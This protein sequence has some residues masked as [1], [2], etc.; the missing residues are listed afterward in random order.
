MGE[1]EV[2]VP[3]GLLMAT[4][5]AETAVTVR[6]TLVV[7]PGPVVVTVTLVGPVGTVIEQLNAPLALAV[8]EH[9]VTLPG[10]VMATTE[11]GVAVPAMGWV[12]GPGTGG[13]TVKVGAP[14]AVKLVVVLAVPPGLVAVAVKVTGPAVT[15]TTQEKL[16]PAVAVVEHSVAL[17]GPVMA[18]TEPGV[19][20]PL[21]VGEVEV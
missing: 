5:G 18:T 15:L 6:G 13:R 3:E 16:P 17:P 10:P 11:P 7:P 9:K 12:T 2:C 8:V 20:V 14:A 1:V 21:T 19:A 4:V